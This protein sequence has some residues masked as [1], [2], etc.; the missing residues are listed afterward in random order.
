MLPFDETS[1]MGWGYDLV[2]PYVVQQENLKMGIIDIAYINHSI[3]KTAGFYSHKTST[4]EM[5]VFLNNNDH[6]EFEE[7]FTVLNKIRL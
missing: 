5:T 3:R 1:P 2:W 4:D 7:A 6:I